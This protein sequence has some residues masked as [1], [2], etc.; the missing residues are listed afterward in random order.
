MSLIFDRT[1]RKT[2]V[3]RELCYSAY[4]NT[5]LQFLGDNMITVWRDGDVV[6]ANGINSV[7]SYGWIHHKKYDIIRSYGE[8]YVF[9]I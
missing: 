4:G 2:K 6:L 8:C 9:D 5:Q 1:E 3:T 7:D